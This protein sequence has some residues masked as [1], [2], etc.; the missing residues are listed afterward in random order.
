MMRLPWLA[1]AFVCA[2]AL[3]Q[4]PDLVLFNGRIHTLDAKSTVVQALAVRDGRIV[5]LGTSAQI[6]KLVGRESRGE[7]SIVDLRGRTVIPGLIDSHMH[8]IRAALSFSTEVN[9]IG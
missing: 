6:K 1:C 7:D 4:A 9:W 3:A 8:A 5:A 2:S